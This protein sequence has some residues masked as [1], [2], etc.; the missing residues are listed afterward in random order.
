MI[1]EYT[2]STAFDVSTA[3]FDGA[4]EAFSVR[5]QHTASG[6]V[7]NNDGTKIYVVGGNS[8]DVYEYDTINCL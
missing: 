3:T 7:F 4:D 5:S 8:V 2:L 6:F 1:H